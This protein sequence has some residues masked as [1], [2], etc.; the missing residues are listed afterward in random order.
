MLA[1]APAIS[2]FLHS[3]QALADAPL[4]A[5]DEAS[6]QWTCRGRKQMHG[7]GNGW[8]LAMGSAPLPFQ[9]IGHARREGNAYARVPT[10]FGPLQR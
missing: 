10:K 9:G 7:D 1:M 4:A 8:W 6:V 5:E 2:D 3:Q